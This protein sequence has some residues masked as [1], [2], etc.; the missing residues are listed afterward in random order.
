MTKS[1]HLIAPRHRWSP[2]DLLTLRIGYP[3]LPT[4]L[5]AQHL[6]ISEHRVYAMASACGLRKSAAFHAD[7]KLSGRFD[8][9]S[10]AGEA[11]RFQKGQAPA[12]KGLRRPGWAPGRMRATQFK[13][14]VLNGRAAQLLQPIGS[15]RVNADGYLDRKVRSDGPPQRRWVAVH[16]LVWQEAHGPIPANHVVVFRAGCHTTDVARITDSVLELVS[17]QELMRR[18]SYHTNLPPELA[19]IVQLRGAIQRQINKRLGRE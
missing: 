7:A 13:K 18:N 17:R 15:Y 2:Q 4:K 10:R 3:D 5:I 1:R 9:L 8:K 11:F 6:G 12:N 16:R 14:G 19:R